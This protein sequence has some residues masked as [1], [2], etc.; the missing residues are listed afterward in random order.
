MV[1]NP[2]P[3]PLW[4]NLSP[5]S[6]RAAETWIR[7][8]YA[9]PPADVTPSPLQRLLYALLPSP[10]LGCKAPVWEPRSPG[11][12]QTD[13]LGLCPSCHRSLVRWPQ[14]SCD[15]CGRW[16][17]VPAVPEGYRCGRCRRRTPACDAV[18]STWSYQPPIDAVLMALKFRRLDYLGAHLGR[19]MAEIHRPRLLDRDLVVPVPLFWTRQMARGYNQADAIA[20]PLAAALGIPLARP[21]RRRRPTPPQSRLDRAARRRN[22]E[23]A[24]R[25]RRTAA[26]EGL[27][28]V[29]VDDVVTTGATV[30]ECARTLRAAG[31]RQVAVLALARASRAGP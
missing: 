12:G 30:A 3:V 15:S 21:L 31:A 14:P 29:L 22:L 24:F 8:L 20:G 28:L 9:S 10:C 19:I 17:D 5:R 6:R 25:V 16:L 18:L 23:R 7:P 27:H 26:L 1:W 2:S 11:G 13:S 4:G